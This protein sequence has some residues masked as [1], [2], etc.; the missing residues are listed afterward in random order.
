M[1]LSCLFLRVLTL[2]ILVE[3]KFVNH[4]PE[5]VIGEV[6]TQLL[7]DPSQVS[8]TDFARVVVVKELERPADLVKGVPLDDFF[9]HCVRIG[10]CNGV[11]VERLTA[12]AQ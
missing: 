11:L 2:A 4:R 1:R 3:V 5:L 8:E 7:G 9:A 12:D 10:A 6:L